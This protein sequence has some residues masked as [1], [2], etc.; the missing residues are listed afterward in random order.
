MNECRMQSK[1]NKLSLFD[2]I[3]GFISEW[4]SFPLMKWILKLKTSQNEWNQNKTSSISENWNQNFKS[5]NFGIQ[6]EYDNSNWNWLD[7]RLDFWNWRTFWRGEFS[8]EIKQQPPINQANAFKQG[9]V[10]VFA[11]LKLS[12]LWLK[13]NQS[14]TAKPNRKNPFKRHSVPAQSMLPSHSSAIRL[15]L[16]SNLSYCGII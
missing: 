4:I 3:S 13:A 2:F 7:W 11:G 6:F 1:R 5:L 14:S 12:W 10:V 9:L 15:A 8:F 16:I